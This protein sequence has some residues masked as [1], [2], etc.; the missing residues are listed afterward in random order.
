MKSRKPVPIIVSSLVL[1][2]DG[3]VHVPPLSVVV[4]QPRGGVV[5]GSG[6]GGACHNE[7]PF[8]RVQLGQGSEIK[9]GRSVSLMK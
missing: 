8:V 2:H 7:G 3:V 6:E 1:T 4:P 5:G 9:Q